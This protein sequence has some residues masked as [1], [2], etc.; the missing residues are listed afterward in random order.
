[1]SMPRRACTA[2]TDRR[3]NPVRHD[4]ANGLLQPIDPFPD[5]SHSQQ[6]FLESNALLAVLE[7]EAGEP[8]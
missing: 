8:V 1:M 7:L 4:L 6:H 2:S 5:L 3:Q